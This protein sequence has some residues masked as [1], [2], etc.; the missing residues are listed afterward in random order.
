VLGLT[1]SIL[2]VPGCSSRPSTTSAPP[3]GDGRPVAVEPITTSELLAVPGLDEPLVTTKPTTAAEDAAVRAAADVVRAFVPRGDG[4]DVREMMDPL[5]SFAAAYPHSGWVASV[6]TDLGLAYYRGGYFSRAFDAFGKAWTEGRPATDWRAKA[7]VDRAVSELAKMH[8]RV[9]HLEPLEALFADL[10]D[11]AMSGAA[12]ELMQGAR[13]GAW[14]MRNNPGIAYLCGPKA[15]KN[16][17]RALGA[18]RTALDVADAARSGEHGFSLAQVDALATR[19]GLAHRLIHRAPGEPVP[20]PSVIH[21][22]VHHYAAV[23][24]RDPSGRFHIEDPT[25]GYGTDLVVTEAAIDEE[26]S[27]FFLVPTPDLE[28]QARHQAIELPGPL[29]AWRE[30]TPEQAA[31]VYG[32]GST[33]GSVTNG[34]TTIDAKMTGS[35]PVIG[36]YPPASSSPAKIGGECTG[37]TPC[38]CSGGMCVPNAHLMEVSLNLNDTPVGY[39]P[40]IGPQVFSRLT[41]NQREVGQPS[42]FTF[43]NV[44]PKWTLN[45]ITYI[46]DDLT[47][48]VGNN[49]TR[50][51][52]GGGFESYS[53]YSSTTG[54]FTGE[55]QTGMVLA[56]TPATGPLTSYTLSAADG[57]SLVFAQTDG[58]T[59]G[60]RKVFLTKVIDPQ[61][62]ALTLSYGSI[63]SAGAGVTCPGGACQ[64]LT[65][66]TDAAGRSTTFGYGLSSAPLLITRITDPFG[67]SASMTYDSSARLSTITDV[68]G[69]TSTFGYD[70][71]GIVTSL[72][73]PYGT[74]TFAYG[75]SGT[76][77]YLE[78]TDPLGYTERV[79]YIDAA[80]GIGSSDPSTPSGLNVQNSFL[81]FRS[82][83]YWD[84]Y[85]YPIYGT[86]AGKD[87]TKAVQ[88]RFAHDATGTFT[89]QGVD[90]IKR[91]LESRLWYN[92]GGGFYF[93]EGTTAAADAPTAMAR[94]LD[95]GST[96]L[97]TAT[98]NPLGNLTQVVDPL[99]RTTRY[100]YAANNIDVASIQQLTAS[101]STY[102]T[103]ATYTY[104]SQ[105][106]PLTYVDAA[107]QIWRYCYNSLGQLTQVIDP[108]SYVSGSACGSYGAVGTRYTY[109]TSPPYRLT[110]VTDALGNTYWTYTYSSTCTGGGGN[111]CD[112]PLTVQD[113]TAYVKTY[114]RD[115]LDRTTTVTYTSDTYQTTERYDYTFQGGSY[116]GTP[117]LELRRF[118]D[119]LGRVTAFVYDAGRRLTAVTDPSSHSVQYAYFKNGARNTQTDQNGHVT[120]WAIDL[121]SRPTTKTFADARTI[122]YAYEATTPRLKSVTD[123]LSQVKTYAYDKA[124]E[125]TGI[126]YT[127]AVNT[128]PNV[129]FAW[130]PYFPRRTQMTDGAGTT[131]W[132][133]VASGTRGALQLLTEDGPYANDAATYAYDVDGRIINQTIGGT[134]AETWTYDGLGRVADHATLL[135]TFSYSSY[136][137]ESNRPGWRTLGGS[138]VAMGWLYGTSADWSYMRKAYTSGTQARNFGEWYE[139]PGGQFSPY[140]LPLVYEENGSSGHPWPARN[141]SYTYDNLDRLTGAQVTCTAPGGGS[142]GTTLNYTYA[143]D[144]A[145]NKTTLADPN[146]D[147]SGWGQA[148]NNLNEMTTGF[149]F[150]NAGDRLSDTPYTYKWD[151]EDR[152]IEFKYAGAAA[153]TNYTYDGLGRRLQSAYYNGTTTT[154]TRYQ[155][156]RALP[157][158]RPWAWASAP[159]ICAKRD[160]SDAVM[161]R[162]YT[163]GEYTVSGALK[164]LYERDQA[165]SV[166]DTVDTSGN[167]VGALDYSPY[168][169]QLRTWGAL[170]DYQFEGLFV[171]QPMGVNFS[172]TRMYD[173]WDGAWVSRDPIAERG[174]INLFAYAGGNPVMRVDPS[175]LDSLFHDDMDLGSANRAPPRHLLAPDAQLYAIQVGGQFRGFDGPPNIDWLKIVSAGGDN[176]PIDISGTNHAIGHAGQF[177]FQADTA[178]NV[179]FNDYINAS[180]VAV[181]YYMYGAGHQRVSMLAVGDLYS[182]LRS[183]RSMYEQ[184][185]WWLAGYTAASQG[186]HPK[187]FGTCE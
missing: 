33:G 22:K 162:Y 20:V 152:L 91:P 102:T 114:A 171:D 156:C 175:G 25:F 104:N 165:G 129:T 56:R 80:P 121:E 12:T 84:K 116:A 61:G 108:A 10:G 87:Y 55:V 158:D 151:A 134:A 147:G 68:L 136:Q 178:S 185:P 1:V 21:W 139:M 39:G 42:V 168:G 176:G 177:N 54:L 13:E 132:S 77:R 71:S 5:E 112:L 143:Y 183:S 144:P 19:A 95:D 76:T 45:W 182:W 94:L 109:E 184:S 79:E 128:T 72:A 3:P 161:K 31:L 127:A 64:I 155:W 97:S 48:G 60:T 98:V 157:S 81:N 105:H 4:A 163:E 11:R 9:G 41:F 49:V 7:I 74:S 35:G 125:L 27:G 149:T 141:W 88:Y 106:E 75:T 83:Y 67:R 145:G 153:K 146:G 126:A 180:N 16:V 29:G 173:P 62:N 18:P 111:N 73:T 150:N 167:L 130:D 28:Q 138:P 14:T 63:A 170:P 118:T 154:S 172:A 50:Y 40:Q 51:S 34:T 37:A 164:W 160:G 122:A 159:H 135:G 69:I 119:R 66:I 101:P 113:N 24:S 36:S 70:A 43:S 57:S 131:T 90:S 58:A 92:R 44:S 96:Q 187:G 52:S 23:M 46:Q 174:G 142:C 137:N 65:S 100:T 124:N 166:R 26:G 140:Y 47:A 6:Y 179:V 169:Q 93:L 78:L 115:A 110:G 120:T 2:A 123:A 107:G 117:S 59:S 186:I 148:Y 53:G 89:A 85:V 30:V 181:G 38:D 8:A 17:L 99:G 133:Y 82:S 86:G 32:M 103:I 15:L